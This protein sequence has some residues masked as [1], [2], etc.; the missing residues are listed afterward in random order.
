MTNYDVNTNQAYQP[1]PDFSIRDL[2]FQVTMTAVEKHFHIT[3]TCHNKVVNNNCR[4]KMAELLPRFFDISPHSVYH[5]VSNVTLGTVNT[6]RDRIQ[7]GGQAVWFI[8]AHY[9]SSWIHES[10]LPCLIFHILVDVFPYISHLNLIIC[11]IYLGEW[12]VHLSLKCHTLQ[13]MGLNRYF[14]LY[15]MK[16]MIFWDIFDIYDS[17]I[18]KTKQIRARLK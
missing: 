3:S 5:H 14:K 7:N 12:S 11:T 16:S 13:L 9:F 4:P 17:L 15:T 1:A 18:S 8:Q 2:W 10:Q 6:V